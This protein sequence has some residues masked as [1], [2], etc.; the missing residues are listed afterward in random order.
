M[1]KKFLVVLSCAVIIIGALHR[2]HL[3][4]LNHGPAPLI[5]INLDDPAEYADARIPGSIN[6]PLGFYNP[7]HDIDEYAES[8]DKRSNIIVYSSFH[9]HSAPGLAAKRLKDL[10][11]EKVWAYEGGTVEW[12]QRGYPTQGPQKKE[13]LKYSREW[14]AGCTGYSGGQPTIDCVAL[15][16]KMTAAGLLKG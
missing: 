13:W 8:L 9:T 10:G 1:I 7:S 16:D 12:V 2:V 14:P 11:F 3:K 15:K 4:Y 6:I 5:I